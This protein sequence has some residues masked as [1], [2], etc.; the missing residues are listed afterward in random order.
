M[1]TAL[2][3]QSGSDTIPQYLTSQVVPVFEIEPKI[4]NLMRTSSNTATGA[5]TIYTTPAD[6]DFYL[7]Y[8]NLAFTKN[9]ASDCT[10]V[11]LKAF[12]GGQN[13]IVCD[14]SVQTLTAT[15]NSISCPL[16]YPI[17]IDRGT[18]ISTNGSF[19]VGAMNKSGTV[20]GFILE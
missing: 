11:W 15:S 16:P 2:G 5:S 19:T 6:K 7:T 8:Y 1:Q 3:L 13:V 4:T 9:A 14:F 10:E 18:A 20:G 17:K 12:I